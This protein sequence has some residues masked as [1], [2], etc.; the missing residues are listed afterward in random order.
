MEIKW[1]QKW[2]TNEHMCE[3]ERAQNDEISEV[4]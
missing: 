1:K 2:N 3:M 4:I